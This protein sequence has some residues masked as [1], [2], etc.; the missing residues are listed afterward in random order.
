MTRTAV[1]HTCSPAAPEDPVSALPQTP[2]LKRRFY[3]AALALLAEEG[4]GALKQR[5]L[6]AR[7]GLTT[8][9]FFHSFGN[10]REFVQLLL[11]YWRADQTLRIRDLVE[12][13]DSPDWQVETLLRAA[14]DLPHEAEGALRAWGGADPDVQRVVTQVDAERLATV[15]FAF[16]ALTR[17]A[18]LS[19]RLARTAMWV[20]IGFEQ[21]PATRDPDTLEFALRA[22]QL[23]LL[24]AAGQ[25]T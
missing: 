20:L 13:L 19:D 12:S 10:W 18:V 22:I 14:V 15:A 23:Q 1:E 9:A 16:T 5:A 17:D 25:T 3:D 8:G 7:M 21:S 6:V 24:D 11:E 2:E 4:Y